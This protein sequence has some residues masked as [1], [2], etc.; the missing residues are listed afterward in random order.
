M[1]GWMD[2]WMDGCLFLFT[3]TPTSDVLERLTVG[4]FNDVFS[5][6]WVI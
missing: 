4:V 5:L 6:A 3:G 1:D 2:G